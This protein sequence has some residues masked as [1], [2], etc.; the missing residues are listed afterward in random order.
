M[1]SA[2]SEIVR[3]LKQQGFHLHSAKGRHEVW[4]DPSDTC[5]IRIPH[6]SMSQH[7]ERAI[8]KQIRKANEEPKP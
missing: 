2:K 6:A 5:L 3:L 7:L 1:A 8:H 4:K